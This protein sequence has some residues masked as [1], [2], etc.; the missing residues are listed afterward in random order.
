[1][2]EFGRR[3]GRSIAT[4]VWFFRDKPFV[5]CQVDWYRP[6]PLLAHVDEHRAAIRRC[7]ELD[8]ADH[9]DITTDWS[10]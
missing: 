1:M 2:T 8:A 7:C 3:I 9:D 4:L 6:D 5:P 10:R